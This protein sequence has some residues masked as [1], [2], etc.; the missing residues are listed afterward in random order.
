MKIQIASDLHLEHRRDMPVLN[1]AGADV[2]ILSGDICEAEHLYKNPRDKFTI[3]GQVTDLSQTM[4]NDWRGWY[5]ERY[6]KFFQHCSDNWDHVIYV[7]GNHEHYNGRWERTSEVL[8][9]EMNYYDNISYCDQRRV[10]IDG[11]QFLGVGLW[12]DF[13]KADPVT[14]FTVKDYMSDYRWINNFNDGQWGRLRPQTTL[15]QHRADL[16]WLRTMLAEHQQPTVIVGHHAPSYQS[17]HEMYKNQPIM[18]YAFCSD[19]DDF[20]LEH[21][22]IALWTHGH[23]HN[24]FDYHIGSTHV[25]CNPL[26]YP[27]EQNQFNP[28]LVIEI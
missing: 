9:N 7:A 2:L 11:V 26:G 4:S 15:N 20:I 10:Q 28:E 19:L 6:R 1:N 22:H 3:D 13:N 24:A 27:G 12:T 16:E 18:N 8:L 14:M 25:I 23:V 21:E 17:I 5:A